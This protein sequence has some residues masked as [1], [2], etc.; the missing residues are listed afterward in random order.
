MYMYMYIIKV[1]VCLCVYLQLS[2]LN[3]V[4]IIISHSVCNYY[5]NTFCRLHDSV[6]YLTV[7][8]QLVD[9]ES[10]IHPQKD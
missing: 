2:S 9:I 4:I 6:H 5:T 1:C 7:S 10:I 3:F 8:L